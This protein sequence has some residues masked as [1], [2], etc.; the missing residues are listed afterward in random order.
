MSIRRF[1]YTKRVKIQRKDVHCVLERR[2]GALQFS[3][4]IT[5]GGYELP[6]D[7]EVFLEAT[8][9]I[10]RLRFPWGSVAA[11]R[12]PADRVLRKF[13]SEDGIGFRLVVTE[14]PNSDRRGLIVAEASNIKPELQAGDLR[15]GRSLLPVSVEPTLGQTLW[16]IDFQS[17]GPVLQVNPGVGGKAWCGSAEFRSAVLP[18]CVREVLLYAVLNEMPPW[19]VDAP[20]DQNWASLWLWFAHELPG[21]SSL[22]EERETYEDIIAWLDEVMNAFARHTSTM[23]GWRQAQS[24]SDDT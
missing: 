18:H 16:K 23:D 14:A 17:S 12:Q 13:S 21:V 5:L 9:G 22:P 19:P 15:G 20:D 2:D 6:P 11:P 24:G 4:D 3:A 10:E 1:N 7:A 8:R